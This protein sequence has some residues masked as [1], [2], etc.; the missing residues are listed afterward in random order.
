MPANSYPDNEPRMTVP[1]HF[2]HIRKTGGMAIKA[3]LR[4][5]AAEYGIVLHP[6]TTKLQDL[7]RFERVFF[8]VR[9]PVARFVSGFNSRL[10]MGR[11]LLDSKWSEGEAI[12]FANFRTP[13]ELAEALSSD[14]ARHEALL[15]MR[16][17]RHVNAPLTTWISSPEEVRARLCDIV[18][19]LRTETLA[20]D[21]EIVRRALALPP[22][23]RVP[24]D[25]LTSHRTPDG[26]LTSLSPKGRKNI[27]VWY[28]EDER[29]LACLMLMRSELR[30]RFAG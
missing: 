22:D 20:K 16:E 26:F 5:V 21:F 29:L 25:D 12:A 2:L 17:I 24:V 18:W 8:A 13:N 23:I 6:H 1:V 10:R 28:A 30:A 27:E 11:P 14:G 7:P 3:A 19:I 4:P 9:D 15:A